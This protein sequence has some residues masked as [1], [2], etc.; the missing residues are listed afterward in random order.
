MKVL[1]ISMEISERMVSYPSDRKFVITKV[2]EL[3]KG[4]PVNLSEISMNVH[5][6]THL[7]VP[8]HYIKRERC[9]KLLSP[10]V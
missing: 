4:D 7:D 6:G 2:L 1:D 5:T 8:K 10:N 3:I 9:S